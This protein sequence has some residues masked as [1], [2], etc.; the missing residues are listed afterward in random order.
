MVLRR[1]RRREAP[2]VGNLIVANGMADTWISHPHM[3]N[4]PPKG[5]PKE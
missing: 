1:Y 2:L 3:L 4:D 5:L